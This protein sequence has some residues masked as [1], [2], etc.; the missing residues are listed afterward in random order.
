[1]GSFGG[2][3]SPL[4]SS[5]VLSWQHLLVNMEKSSITDAFNHSVSC[6]MFWAL[7]WVNPGRE[8]SP[9]RLLT[10]HSGMGKRIGRVKV[11]PLDTDSLIGK[12]AAVHP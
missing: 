9:T 10:P 8:L 11:S 3:F 5:E 4:Y 6:W 1:M 7:S 2:W 12:A